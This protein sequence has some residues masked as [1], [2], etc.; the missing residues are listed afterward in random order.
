MSNNLAKSAFWLMVVTMLSKILG[1][2]RDIV[3]M[4]FYGTSA[5]SDVYI[6]AMN[7]PVVVF[8]AVGV[9]L[10]TTFIPLYQE[11]LEN[12]GEKRAQNFANN[13]LCIVSIIS[14]I[15]SIFGYIFAEPIVK[16]FAIS[17]TGDKLALTVD[18][19]RIIIVGVLF[20]GLSNIMTAY[21]QIQGN[22]TIPG[23]VQLPNNI[24]I[25]ISMVIGAITKNFD[26]LAIGALIGMAS[27][28]L[29]Q[30][31]FAIK[32]GYKFKPIINFKDKYLKKMIWLI[33]PVLIGVAVNQV[34]AMADRSLA[35]SL[36]DGVIAALNSANKLNFFVLGLFI[37]TIGS[38]IYPTL[39]KLSTTN[40]QKKFAEAVS[41]SVNCVSLIILPITVGAIVLATPIVRILFQR[42]EFNETSTQ[43]TAIA[44]MCYSVGMIAYGLRDILGKI[45]Y[46]LKDT[47]T[48]MINGII[49]V[50]ANIF[51][52]V[53]L[54]QVFGLGGLA[55]ATSLSSIICI[56]LLFR[57]LKKKISY[58]GQDRILR[59]FVKSLIASA[60]MGIATYFVYKLSS[61][62]LGTGFI[63]DVIATGVS[64]LAGAIV[65]G[66]LV[67]KF[68]VREVKMLKNM[69]M[70]KLNRS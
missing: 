16:L 66:V 69:V 3:L 31:P 19:V 36:G 50:I 61:G 68:R 24:I 20:I 21:L 47:K 10:S 54:M 7:I 33:L 18:F 15:L 8:A 53:T 25:I 37:T 70:K 23:M 32:H 14:I 13:I 42:G 64:V 29:F 56:L 40:D 52:D 28:F 39:A 51:F 44:L 55:L 11:A 62:I 6:T 17:F 45:Y 27:Q 1:F 59:T 67:S 38:V 49:A 22:F 48:P 4:Y 26:I 41:T 60:V 12:G 35:S 65:Y 34:N 9:A 46:S 30:V 2:T 63:Q 43:M 57:G 58:Y 5:Y